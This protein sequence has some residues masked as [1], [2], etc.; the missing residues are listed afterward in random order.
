[1]TSEADINQYGSGRAIDNV[2]G[3]DVTVDDALRPQCFHRRCDRFAKVKQLIFR[4]NRSCR[5]Q[6]LPEIAS[7]KIFVCDKRAAYAVQYNRGRSSDFDNVGM[8]Q[9]L[10]EGNFT[11][12]AT[13]VVIYREKFQ[14]SGLVLIP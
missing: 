13:L 9:I 11:I 1:M 2:C 10:E 14:R 7:G 12:Q 4:E 8:V 3:L 6:V 5:R